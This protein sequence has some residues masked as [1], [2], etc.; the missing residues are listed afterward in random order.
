MKALYS[1]WSRTGSSCS[2]AAWAWRVIVRNRIRSGS[3]PSVRVESLRS[4][5]TPRSAMRRASASGT[6]GSGRA[7]VDEVGV[8]VEDGHPQV[9]LQ[10]EPLEEHPE[11]VGLA[12]PALAAEER[13]PV[14]P[15]GPQARLGAD[16]ARAPG[17]DRSSPAA[18]TCSAAEL[19]RRRPRSM[20]ARRNGGRSP[21]CTA[22]VAAEG[23]DD[24]PEA[25]SEAS[26]RADR[27][28]ST[29]DD[30]AQDDDSSSAVTTTMS[31]GRHGAR[32]SR[33]EREAPAVAGLRGRL[34]TRV[35]ARAPL[36]AVAGRGGRVDGVPRTSWRMPCC[37][38]RA[39][40]TPCA[41]PAPVPERR[42]GD[43]RTAVGVGR[44][45]WPDDGRG[46][47]PG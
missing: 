4:T 16:V 42:T 38:R 21:R 35:H 10:E 2:V 6:P 7:E 9:G 44:A 3:S 12:R 13:V 19:G 27:S 29:V 8:R 22:P 23:A 14:E 47:A 41:G 45:W 34:G 20:A 26:V 1:S 28:C 37:A 5:R 32:R 24:D 30:L 40:S 36:A 46:P 11:R 39:R 17:A 15:A 18:A 31:P 43:G 33:V 25:R